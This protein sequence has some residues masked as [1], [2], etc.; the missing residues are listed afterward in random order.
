MRHPCVRLGAP[1]AMATSP[2]LLYEVYLHAE[3]EEEERGVSPEEAR[4]EENASASTDG[5]V[6]ESANTSRTAVRLAR[7]AARGAG[8]L[9][10]RAARASLKLA[11]SPAPVGADEDR[12]HPVLAASA[13]GAELAVAVGGVVRAFRDEDDFQRLLA[14]WSA[15][16]SASPVFSGAA[17]KEKHETSPGR[18]ENENDRVVA[19]S[20]AADG[21]AFA[22]ATEGGAEAETDRLNRERERVEEEQG[23]QRGALARR[24][25]ALE[26]RDA[27]DRKIQYP[28][29]RGLVQAQHRL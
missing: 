27:G 6:V 8:G 22:A 13:R 20:W 15:A 25:V 11:G 26:D 21:S 23:V 1:G 10:V 16:P 7:R 3:H 4:A 14:S 17:G 29:K 12:R 9:A 28:P 18:F 24:R 5:F 2:P 19:L